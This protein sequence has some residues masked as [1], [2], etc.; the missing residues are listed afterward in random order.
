MVCCHWRFIFN[1]VESNIKAGSFAAVVNSLLWI[2]ASFATYP[3]SVTLW[4]LSNA[5]LT[6]STASL[7][8]HSRGCSVQ[9]IQGNQIYINISNLQLKKKL[10]W[11]RCKKRKK[12]KTNQEAV[13]QVVKGTPKGAHAEAACLQHTAPSLPGEEDGLTLADSE[14][15]TGQGIWFPDDESKAKW[16]GALPFLMGT[17]QGTDEWVF[18]VFGWWLLFFCSMPCGAYLALPKPNG[19]FSYV[20]HLNRENSLWSSL[21]VIYPQ[22]S[23][24]L[25]ITFHNWKVIWTFVIVHYNLFLCPVFPGQW[26]LTQLCYLSSFKHHLS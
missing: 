15:V 2:T 25:N 7:F 11:Q 18:I 12:T 4:E 3:F 21:A 22:L 17:F 1:S 9:V 14:M 20:L 16:Q 26:I 6:T 24:P 19:H 5:C 8:V 10:C 23:L 13:L